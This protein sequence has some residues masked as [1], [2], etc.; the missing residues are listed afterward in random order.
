MPSFLRSV[1]AWFIKDSLRSSEV[2][3]CLPC[4]FLSSNFYFSFGWTMANVRNPY[5]GMELE[6]P[7]HIVWS[8]LPMGCI[9][10]EEGIGSATLPCEEKQISH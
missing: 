8:S 3:V 10:G 7:R 2:I 6:S 1:S 4:G 5:G 9:Y